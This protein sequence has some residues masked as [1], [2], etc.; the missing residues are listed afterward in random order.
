MAET[1]STISVVSFIAAGIFV[2]LAIAQWFL[3]NIP[4]VWGDLSGKNARKSIERMRKNNEKSGNKYY[5]SSKTNVE[6]G[7]LTG[8]MEGAGKTDNYGNSDET[9][10]LKE[11]MA[12]EY[13]NSDTGLLSDSDMT[14][15]LKDTNETVPLDASEVKHERKAPDIKVTLIDETMYIHTEEVI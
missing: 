8:T 3:F 6:R 5:K 14:D 13:E 12:T 1:L 4:A 11:N 2:V 15:S 10:L 7:K 9:G